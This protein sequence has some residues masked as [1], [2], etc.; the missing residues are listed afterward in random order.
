MEVDDKMAAVAVASA[1]RMGLG[2]WRVAG[3]TAAS[4]KMVA[5]ELG[6]SNRRWSSSTMT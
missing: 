1:T 4:G 2:T 6:T 5:P 3:R